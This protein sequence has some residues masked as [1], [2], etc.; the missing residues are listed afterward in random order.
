MLSCVARR[1]RRLYYTSTSASIWA[2]ARRHLTRCSH[3][4][5]PS[6]AWR[7]V[8]RVSSDIKHRRE[9]G[10]NYI[11]S[12]I[13]NSKAI[14]VNLRIVS[15]ACVLA[16]LE[17]FT[18]SLKE[19]SDRHRNCCNPWRER[20]S[21]QYIIIIYYARPIFSLPLRH[22]SLARGNLKLFVVLSDL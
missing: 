6:N 21:C 12:A 15:M 13:A 4:A 22:G 19:S 14:F 17:R 18:T 10:Y 20:R 7:A 16:V 9:G 1:R 2:F 8:Y 5:Y 11:A 3:D